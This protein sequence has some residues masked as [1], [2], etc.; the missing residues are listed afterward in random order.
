[1]LQD[2]YRDTEVFFR[3]KITLRGDEW[4]CDWK[5]TYVGGREEG[6]PY[7]RLK[8]GERAIGWPEFIY[9]RA[10]H[11]VFC[12]STPPSIVFYYFL[13][14]RVCACACMCVRACVS[15]CARGRMERERGGSGERGGTRERE[16]LG[17]SALL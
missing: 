8:K 4:D 2:R 11:G 5:V 16:I 6:E 10:G 7:R 1:M 14:M 12:Y 15:V 17:K 3:H 13:C 9:Q